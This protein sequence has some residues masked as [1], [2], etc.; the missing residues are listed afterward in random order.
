MTM[1]EL[2]SSLPLNIELAV[3]INSF[4]RLQLLR[5][6]LPSIIKALQKISLQSAIIV[7]DAGSTDGSI[8]FVENFAQQVPTPL[9]ICLSPSADLDRSFSAGCN[10]AIQYA[11]QNFPQLKWCFFFETDNLLANESALPL[12][13]KLMEQEETLAAVGFTVERCDGQKTGFGSRF[14]TPLAFLLGQQL[15]QKLGL[16]QMQIHQW[17]SFAETRWGFSDIVFTSPLLVRYSAWQATDGMDSLTFPFSESDNDWCWRVYKQGWR[18]AVLDVP[19]VIHDNRTQSSAWSGERVVNFHQARLRLL[20]KH[21]G[22][23]I[24]LL[25]YLLF[26]RHCLEFFVL[27]FRSV[28]SQQ[29]KKSLQHRW[30]LLNTVLKSYETS[31][32]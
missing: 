30:I 12:A 13:I 9:I 1:S 27:L 18:S 4:N 32:L 3:I 20:L 24:G 16:E 8:E 31:P 21:K 7:F 26:I 11:A 14:P 23:W 2:Q 29:A 19:G 17:Y 6:A 28:H 22:Q 5:E 25:K 15:S 10:F